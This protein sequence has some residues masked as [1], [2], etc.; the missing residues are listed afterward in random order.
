MEIA[1]AT[2]FGAVKFCETRDVLIDTVEKAFTKCSEASKI[3]LA[4]VF[5][6]CTDANGWKI[7]ICL[8]GELFH[9]Y[10]EIQ[11]LSFEEFKAL[12]FALKRQRYANEPKNREKDCKKKKK[13]SDES[14]QERAL[15]SISRVSAKYH[16]NNPVLRALQP[17][18]PSKPG[19]SRWQF[20]CGINGCEK[21]VSIYYEGAK[22]RIR[23][24]SYSFHCKKGHSGN[25]TRSEVSSL[26]NF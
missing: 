20:Y 13:L 6:S 26:H 1:Q 21:K 8:K 4:E 3:S 15:E 22:N 12:G 25:I 18:A 17:V 9:I 23:P 16:T 10:Q 7:H 14:L 19:Y 5:E 2:T 11:K 24:G